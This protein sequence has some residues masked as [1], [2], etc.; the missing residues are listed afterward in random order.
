MEKLY[1]L[2]HNFNI[3]D[4]STGTTGVKS[5]IKE[6]SD[7]NIFNEALQLNIGFGPESE[8]LYGNM[9][10]L[11]EPSENNKGLIRK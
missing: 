7:S 1:S 6:L 11:I 4:Y 9:W 3:V 2:E 5:G 8:D 10:D